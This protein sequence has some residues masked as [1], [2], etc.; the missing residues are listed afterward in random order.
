MSNV[1]ALRSTST[2]KVYA[3]SL[4]ALLVLVTGLFG[5][6]SSAQAATP[7]APTSV[8]ER[9]VSIASQFNGYRYRYGGASPSGFDCSGLIYY[10]YK[11]LGI[12]LGR[13]TRALYNS[14][15]RVGFNALQPGDIV[16]F[17]N[18]Y[19]PGISHA[20]I[21]MG[22]GRIIHAVNESTGVTI[23]NLNSSYWRSKF[24]TGV[25]P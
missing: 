19:R 20:A 1:R 7:A 3:G 11:Q 4:L 6:V 8:G 13:D 10:T 25:R 24:T 12:T 17:S 22:G 18:T 14:G 5:N 21:Y 15:T 23:S 9:A 16:L 2:L